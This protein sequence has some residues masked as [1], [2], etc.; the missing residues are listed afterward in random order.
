MIAVMLK[1]KR[2]TYAL[3][4]ENGIARINRQVSK[5][6]LF[7]FRGVFSH[8]G[9]GVFEIPFGRVRKHTSRV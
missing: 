7:Q 4:L 5:T 9:K 6:T 8:A 2:L 1:L 3:I